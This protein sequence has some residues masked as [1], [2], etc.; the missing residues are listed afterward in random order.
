MAWNANYSISAE[1]LCWVHSLYNI[2]LSVT[3]KRNV[4]LWVKCGK[5]VYTNMEKR[6][7]SFF[8]PIFFIDFFL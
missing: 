6:K 3:D 4:T 2:S 1:C 8:L 7:S 5:I